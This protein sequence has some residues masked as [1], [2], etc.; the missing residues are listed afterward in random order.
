MLRN[1]LAL[2]TLGLVL[3]L[4]LQPVS[5]FASRWGSPYGDPWGFCPWHSFLPATYGVIVTNDPLVRTNP[6]QST[7]WGIHR[8][9]GYDD[10]YGRWYG[11]FAGRPGDDSGWR[12]LMRVPYGRIG[13]WNFASYGW[14]VHGHAKQ[15]IAY[16][17]WT[18][19]GQCG[20]GWRG[21][22][23]PPPYM[24]DV[25]GRP[26][27][28]I[29]VDSVPPEAPRPRVTA[30]GPDSVTLTWDPIVDVGDGAGRDY[31]VAGMDHYTSWL[32]LNG[33]PPMDLANT[34]RPRVVTAM[35]LPPGTSACL[36]VRAFD[37]LQN[38]TREQE[39]CGSPAPPPPMPDLHLSTFSVRANPLPWG[40]AGL[41]SWLWIEPAPVATAVSE[42]WFGSTYTICSELEGV[43]WNFGDGVTTEVQGRDGAGV[44]YPERSTVRHAYQA[45]SPSRLVT[46]TLRFVVTWTLS[47]PGG[48]DVG[49]F[50]LGEVSAAAQPLDYSI[51]QAQPELLGF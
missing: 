45:E 11:D 42:T 28:D 25:Y 17:N 51:R 14:A 4:A 26:V 5:A 20:F 16:Y 49:P 2:L 29:Y 15:Y 31:F 46:A 41:E 43:A 24:A 27:L 22:S 1:R 12:H 40:L 39:A 50:P 30:V 47:R 44:A 32:T 35:H 18:F 19:G 34:A 7:F 38:A 10:W 33:G 37:R 6:E 8:V 48:P 9:P 36:H 21:R 23:T 13:H 3:V